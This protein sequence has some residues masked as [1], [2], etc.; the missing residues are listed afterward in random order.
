MDSKKTEIIT[1]TKSFQ[2]K[3]QAVM[4]HLL[5]HGYPVD[6]VRRALL[7]LND[8]RL[9]DLARGRS[10]TTVSNTLKARRRSRVVIDNMAARLGLPAE[11]LFPPEEGH[12][13]A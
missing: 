2:N 3:N 5:G 7:I 1:M 13:G 8:I 12:D 9:T 10:L 4:A 11:M 6:R